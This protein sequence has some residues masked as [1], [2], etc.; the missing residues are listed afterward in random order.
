MTV[1]ASLTLVFVSLRQPWD[2]Q[3]QPIDENIRLGC[4][5]SLA[6][7][8]AAMSMSQGLDSLIRSAQGPSSADALDFGIFA[9]VLLTLYGPTKMLNDRVPSLGELH[10]IVKHFV[11][12][13]LFLTIMVNSFVTVP[14]VYPP[15]VQM[16]LI[17]AAATILD[18]LL[19]LIAIHWDRIR[20]TLMKCA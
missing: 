8:S 6:I 19:S 11:L 2:F 14:F 20:P 5:K 3:T 17:A 15:L 4:V 10:D 13:L 18:A 1:L 9:A 12:G 7:F 16:A